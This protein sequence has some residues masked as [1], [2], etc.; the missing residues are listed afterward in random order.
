MVQ[1]LHETNAWFP[2]ETLKTGFWKGPARHSHEEKAM[3]D[4]NIVIVG[5]FLLAFKAILV[6]GSEVAILSLATIKQLGRN[7]I[8]VGVA[9][10]GLGS[11]VTFL[12]V[13]QVFVLLP[14]VIIDFATSIVL[15]Y[16]SSRFLRGFIKYAFKHKSFREKMARMEKEVVDKDLKR[17][18]ANPSL[19]VVPFS[20]PN[21]LPV[22]SITL[23]EGFEASLILAAAGAFN[24]Q[25]TLIGAG[26]SLAVLVVVSAISYDYL[27]RVPRWLLDVIAGVVLLTFGLIFFASGVVSIITGTA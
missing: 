2:E 5:S 25:W 15:F 11:V 24:L 23:T 20:I 10:G 9:L 21:S 27:M 18:G 14:A 12:V 17:E 6:E 22:L 13:R 16:F 7:N 26:V 4:P 19:G 1:S 8:L 3:T